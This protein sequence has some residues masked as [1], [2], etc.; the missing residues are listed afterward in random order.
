MTKPSK[1]GSARKPV[2]DAKCLELAEYFLADSPKGLSADA[3]AEAIQ[4]TIEDFLAYGEM[5]PRAGR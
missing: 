2:F 4:L 5:Q 1:K 3:L